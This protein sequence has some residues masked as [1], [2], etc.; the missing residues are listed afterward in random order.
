MNFNV[1]AIKDAI[2]DLTEQERVYLWNERCEG[3]KYYDDYID[4]NDI[5]ELLCGRKPSEV[6]SEVDTGNY[7]IVDDWVCNTIYGYRSFNYLEDNNSP[8]DIDELVEWYCDEGYETTTYLDAEDFII[9]D[10]DEDNE[11]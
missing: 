10:E 8:F 7:D 2:D 9:E 4:N 6:F 11:E 5:D 3:Y 1:E